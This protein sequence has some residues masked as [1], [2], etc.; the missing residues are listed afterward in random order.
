MKISLIV[1]MAS[2]RVIGL[3]NDMPW[4]LSADLRYFRKITM[5]KPI[6]MG[7]KTFESIGR[8]LPG[9]KNIIVS[10]NTEFR[11]EGCLVFHSIEDALH[12]CK[13]EEEVMIVGG[14]CFYETLLP[15]ADRIYLTYIHRPFE[16]DTFFPEFDA[17]DWREIER[18]DVRDDED[19]EFD[20]SF[21][22]LENNKKS[23]F[24]ND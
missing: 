20:Y 2:N 6:L 24:R 5:G 23:Q 7:R 19:V 17:G 22:T 9:R 4:R 13:S 15:E 16:G 1:A 12:V 3:N 10:R 11:R 21:I 18:L 14:A 8:P